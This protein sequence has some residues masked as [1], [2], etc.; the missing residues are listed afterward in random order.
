M[1]KRN[2][3]QRRT[4]RETAPIDRGAAI[5]SKRKILRLFSLATLLMVVI[6]LLMMLTEWAAIYNTDLK[7]YEV[8]IDGF[9]CASAALS[10]GY[11][12]IDQTTY[13][14]IAVFN[15]HARAYVERLS[16]VS[17]IVLFVLIVHGV[18]ALFG[19]ITNKQGVFNILSIIFALAEAALF[20]ACH[21]IGVSFNDSG[22]LTTY[23]NDNPACSVQSQAILPALFAI[24][25]LALPIVALI[26]DHKIKAEMAPLPEDGKEPAS[27]KGKGRK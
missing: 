4:T 18:I 26:R 5:T 15:Y 10:D 7:G 12:S 27:P 9:N 20:I 24:L 17:V 23:C 16:V 22:I 21:A 13:G 6:L 19:L 25:S 3:I 1:A 2:N 8:E 11:K 14:D